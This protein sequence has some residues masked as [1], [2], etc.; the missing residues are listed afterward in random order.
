[1]EHVDHVLKQL[2]SP[3]DAPFLF[4][5]REWCALYR[6]GLRLLEQR[7][8]KVP[9]VDFANLADEIDLMKRVSD[10]LD[11]P[12]PITNWGILGDWVNDLDWFGEK[13][14]YILHFAHTANAWAGS[15]VAMGR[16]SA[17][18]QG[19]FWTWREKKRLFKAVYE[20]S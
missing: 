13:E 5:E 12:A 6:E 20:L 17:E 16:L 7:G 9:T 18:L 14:G 2:L 15:P 1:L 8:Y 10:A 19:A 3:Y 4:V 11:G